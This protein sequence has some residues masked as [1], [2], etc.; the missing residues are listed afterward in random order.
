MYRHGKPNEPT[1]EGLQSPFTSVSTVSRGHPPLVSL[2]LPLSWRIAWIVMVMDG[3]YVYPDGLHCSAARFCRFQPLFYWY[4][5]EL[6]QP[7]VTTAITHGGPGHYFS[8]P[9]PSLWPCP[10]GF[11]PT[12]VLLKLRLQKGGGGGVTATLTTCKTLPPPS[13]HTDKK[14]KK[15]FLILYKDVQNGALAKSYMTNG[16]LIYRE[17]FAHFLIY[18]EA[19]PPI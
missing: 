14:E 13:P 17:K 18:S 11:G 2:V 7:N 8:R 4:I 10:C 15:I 5:I 12:A 1:K 3:W 6:T 9:M 19:L 16:L